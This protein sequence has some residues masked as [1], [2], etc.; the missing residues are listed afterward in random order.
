M[1]THDE[2][3]G[4]LQQCSYDKITRYVSCD[5]QCPYFKD[6]PCPHSLLKDALDYIRELERERNMPLVI[7]RK[8]EDGC[9][10]P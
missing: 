8:N 7:A 2:I 1:K 10:H 4:G 6:K 3:K 9:T 5:E